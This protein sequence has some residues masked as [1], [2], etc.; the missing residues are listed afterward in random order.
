MNGAGILASPMLTGLHAF[1]LALGGFVVGY[2]F[3]YDPAVM[4]RAP[5]TDI[6]MSS[7]LYLAALTLMS[8]GFVGWLRVNLHLWAR[9]PLVAAGVVLAFGGIWPVWE[10]ALAAVAVLTV[11]WL[12]PRLIGA[13]APVPRVVTAD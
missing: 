5:L 13:P 9:P 10:R 8:A 11:L 4:L 2:A 12:V 6:V 3:L 7:V 1:R